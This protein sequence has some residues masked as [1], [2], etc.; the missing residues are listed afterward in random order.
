MPVIEK[1]S[2]S[3]I[4]F[5]QTIAQLYLVDGKH[6]NMANQKFRYFFNFVRNTYGINIKDNLRADKQRLSLLSKLPVEA[7]DHIM[8]N[9]V[10]MES[11]PDTTADE[12]KE[13]VT[14]IN[15]FYKISG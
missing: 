14:L 1:N 4:E 15:N 9:Y 10:K 11:L 12:L 2:N 5:A 8:F 13:T 6:K 7:I 3:S